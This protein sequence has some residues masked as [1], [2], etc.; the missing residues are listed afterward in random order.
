M[1]NIWK[2]R[3]GEGPDTLVHESGLTA[4]QVR[5]AKNGARFDGTPLSPAE[6]AFRDAFL[7]ARERG[8][9]LVVVDTTVPSP[10]RGFVFR[11]GAL[12]PANLTYPDDFRVTV[13][14][15]IQLTVAAE[16]NPPPDDTWHEVKRFRIRRSSV[17]G[18]YQMQFEREETPS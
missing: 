5:A 17:D 7:G 18:S 13:L 4:T 8:H 12:P 3:A 2:G 11:M 10:N 15:G 14:T 9:Y 1:M 6:Q 16:L